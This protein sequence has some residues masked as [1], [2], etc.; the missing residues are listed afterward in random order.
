M[1]F[2]SCNKIITKKDDFYNDCFEDWEKKVPIEW[3]K[4]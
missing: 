3:K 1:I 2:K 4:T